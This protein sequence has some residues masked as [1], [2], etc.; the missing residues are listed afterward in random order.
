MLNKLNFPH[1]LL[2][3]LGNGVGFKVFSQANNLRG[4]AMVQEILRFL[5]AVGI[6][7]G[8]VTVIER[9]AGA[10]WKTSRRRTKR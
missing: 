9:L 6:M 1:D 3:G 4:V 2:L 10:T 5:L 8:V 7:V